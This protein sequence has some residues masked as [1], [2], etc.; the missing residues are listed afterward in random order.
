MG[1]FST[2]EPQN[3]GKNAK[4]LPRN[5]ENHVESVENRIA[6]PIVIISQ[7][8]TLTNINVTYNMLQK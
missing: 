5:V 1:E 4:K 6:Q 8:V 7:I 2:I 3:G